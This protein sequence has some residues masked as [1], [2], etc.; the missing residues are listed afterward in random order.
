MMLFKK[1][2][3]YLFG[4]IPI[5][6]LFRYDLILYAEKN[7]DA[8]GEIFLA[9]LF[10]GS[11]NMEEIKVSLSVLGLLG[12]VYFSLLFVDYIVQDFFVNAEYIFSRCSNRKKWYCKKLMGTAGY[13][14]IG[15]F[16]YLLFYIFAGIRESEQRIDMQDV[17]LIF[18][19]FIML[20]LFLY[21][22]I[23]CINICVLYHGTTIG[24]ILFY[25]GLIVSTIF[26]LILQKQPNQKL[27]LILH[28]LN[29]MSNIFVSW[30]FSNSYVIWGMGY[31]VVLCVLASVILWNI[32]KKYEIG[33]NL[34]IET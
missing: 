25:S 2:Y 24:F 1:K 8:V 10:G 34:R 23:V 27:A 29:P 9:H 20:M 28:R 33:I 26:T 32:V 11:Y 19:T 21:F 4:V 15:I 30:N 5:I 22:S 7:E 6:L 31:Y 18:C 3:K 13:S 16:L 12:I 17:M 14:M